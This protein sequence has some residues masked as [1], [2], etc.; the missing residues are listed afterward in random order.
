MCLHRQA[1]VIGH[2]RGESAGA[3]SLASLDSLVDKARSLAAPVFAASLLR[4]RQILP[5]LLRW[6]FSARR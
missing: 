4:Q 2:R 5:F 3:N 6:A 1:F